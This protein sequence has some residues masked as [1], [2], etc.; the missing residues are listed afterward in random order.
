[1]TFKTPWRNH[2][3]NVMERLTFEKGLF[4]GYPVPVKE[5]RVAAILLSGATLHIGLVIYMFDST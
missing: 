1:M 5:V 4:G 3:C 2:E